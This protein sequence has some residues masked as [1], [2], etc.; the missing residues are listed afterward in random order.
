MERRILV[1]KIN[2]GTRMR[3]KRDKQQSQL[4]S[5][6]GYSPQTT[7]RRLLAWASQ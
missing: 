1:F 2:L 6:H 7:Q 4:T 5:Q 3:P